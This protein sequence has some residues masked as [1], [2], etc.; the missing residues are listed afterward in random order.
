[1]NSNSIVWLFIAILSVTSCG[2]EKSL[3]DYGLRKVEIEIDDETLGELNNSY[4]AKRPFAA[5]VTIDG[6]EYRTDLNYAGKS[7]L[8]AFKKSF[9]LSFKDQ[10]TFKGRSSLRLSSQYV[11]NSLLRS[12]IGFKTFSEAGVIS[13]DVEPAVVYLN[14]R[15]QGLYHMIEPVDEEFFSVR[16]LEV[17]D[18][19]KAKFANAGFDRD[20]IDRLGDAYSV[21]LDPKDISPLRYL[22]E[23]ALSNDAVRANDNIEKV[24]DVD[25]YLRY[26]AA[27]VA[28]NH[29]D[30]FDNNYFLARLRDGRFRM[31]PWDLDRVFEDR[32]YEDGG[33]WGKNG[34]TNQILQNVE[35]RQ[36][37]ISHLERVISQL[38][39]RDL[40][41]EI[42]SW[43]KNLRSAYEDDPIISSRAPIDESHSELR[44]N[45]QVWLATLKSQLAAEKAI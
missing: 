34:L 7:T 12:L 24:L 17:K 29:W 27:A 5:L 22:W 30:G 32:A 19:Y 25:Q 11:D 18:L 10:R 39:E 37:Y 2:N 35:Y 8:D 41:S 33:I 6:R 28:M 23:Q 1:M 36:V 3:P 26:V 20:F 40:E 38:E 45:I 31:I 15:Y 9:Q 13:P 4:Q 21:R 43:T 42:D 16:S 44:N 14:G